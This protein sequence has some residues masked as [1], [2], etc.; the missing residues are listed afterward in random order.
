MSPAYAT[1]QFEQIIII[2]FVVIYNI[3]NMTIS[4][5]NLYIT[6]CEEKEKVITWL[7]NI[8]GQCY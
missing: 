1:L 2:F 7:L 3:E 4:Y 6:V 5:R 8:D